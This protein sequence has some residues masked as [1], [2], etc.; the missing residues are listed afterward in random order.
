MNDP[1]LVIKNLTRNKLRLSFNSFAILI[2]FFIFGVL[3]ALNSAFN[4]GIELSADDRLVVVNKINFTQPMPIAYVNKIR[5]IKGVN[6]VTHANWFGA[7]HQDQRKMIVAFAVD[8]TTYLKVY[9]DFLLADEQYKS[10]LNDRQGMVVGERLANAKGWKVGDLVPI[11]SNIFSKVDGSHVWDMRVSG[12]LKGKDKQAD[13]NFLIF[14]YKYFIETQTFGSDWIGWVALTTDHPS[15]NETVARSIDKQFANSAYETETSTEKQFNKAFIE[16]LGSIGLIIS[17]VVFAAFFTILLL[18]GNSM[19]TSVRERTR[20]IAVMKTLGFQAPR[21]FGMILSESLMLSLFG[22]LVGLGL[23]CYTV[24]VVSAMPELRTML[25]NLVLSGSIV[26][27]AV[28]YMIVL[29]LLTGILPAVRA[30][31]LNTI[32]ALSRG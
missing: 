3:G 17:S 16:Q 23:A 22:G 28:F 7:Y 30:M 4:A 32:E 15:L 14:H 18:V 5:A 24:T 6:Q 31:R 21:V 25:P 9:S 8:P 27:Q 1:Y 29:G 20:E 11:S 13:T 10:W 12:I 19:A 26:L 2:A